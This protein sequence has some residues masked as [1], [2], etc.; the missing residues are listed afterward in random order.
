MCNPA[1]GCQTSINL[2][3][4]SEFAYGDHLPHDHAEDRSS[5][6][7]DHDHDHAPPLSAMIAAIMPRP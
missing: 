1:F 3:A 6:H 5:D 4:Y 7:H 2:Q